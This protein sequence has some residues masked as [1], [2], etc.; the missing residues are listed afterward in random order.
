MCVTY[1]NDFVMRDIKS[2]VMYRSV[3]ESMNEYTVVMDGCM[4]LEQTSHSDEPGK[5]NFQNLCDKRWEQILFC[6]NDM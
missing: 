4:L 5:S 6:T 2:G 3:T 1:V